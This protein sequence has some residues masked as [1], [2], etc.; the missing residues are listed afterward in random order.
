MS[1]FTPRT[2]F[3]QCDHCGTQLRAP[4]DVK[5]WTC[6]VCNQQTDSTSGFA[7]RLLGPAA[8]ETRRKPIGIQLTS[9]LDRARGRTPLWGYNNQF[10]AVI[11]PSCGMQQTISVNIHAVQCSNC[12]TVF[13]IGSPTG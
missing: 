11:C 8:A 4:W 10:V 1:L 3:V 12:T 5:I 7:D 2:R 9:A 13:Q 6:P